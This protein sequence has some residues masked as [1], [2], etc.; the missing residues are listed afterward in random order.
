MQGVALLD[1]SGQSLGKYVRSLCTHTGGT[2]A[3]PCELCNGVRATFHG[4]GQ[5]A[6]GA[7]L[8]AVP[9][10]EPGLYAVVEAVLRAVRERVTQGGGTT[11]AAAVQARDPEAMIAVLCEGVAGAL[12]SLERARVPIELRHPWRLMRDE[13]NALIPGS[14]TA[15]LIAACSLPALSS[16]TLDTLEHLPP[17]G[18][19][20]LVLA[21]AATTMGASATPDARVLG[22]FTNVGLL[23]AGT[24]SSCVPAT[25]FPFTPAGRIRG[26]TVKASLAM[27]LERWRAFF[28]PGGG[29]AA[30]GAGV[31]GG[32]LSLRCACSFRKTE[33]VCGAPTAAPAAP[34]PAPAEGGAM[35]A[36]GGSPP[37]VAADADEGGDAPPRRGA[38][39]PGV[40]LCPLYPARAH[41]LLLPAPGGGTVPVQL[42]GEPPTSRLVA[43]VAAAA[44]T[45][46]K[47]DARRELK[48]ADEAA[49]VARLRAPTAA[50]AAVGVAAAAGAA[51]AAAAVAA[52]APAAPAAAGAPVAA[53]APA[54]AAGG[55][56]PAP[57]ATPLPLRPAPVRRVLLPALSSYAGAQLAT[58]LTARQQLAPHAGAILL[59]ALRAR[60]LST[61]VLPLLP[62]GERDG[63]LLGMREAAAALGCAGCYVQQTPSSS[64][65]VAA[66]GGAG[67]GAGQQQAQLVAISGL[68]PLGSLPSAAS[69]RTALDE[70]AAAAATSSVAVLRRH[71][72]TPRSL[73]ELLSDLS[74]DA[75]RA[76]FVPRPFELLQFSGGSNASSPLLHWSQNPAAL[77]GSAARVTGHSLVLPQTAEQRLLAVAINPFYPVVGPGSSAPTQ[78][79][80]GIRTGI[81]PQ[82][83][84][85]PRLSPSSEV[86]DFTH[87][88][89]P[90]ATAEATAAAA[91]DITRALC[92]LPCHDQDYLGGGRYGPDVKA[93]MTTPGPD[94][95]ARKL[96]TVKVGVRSLGA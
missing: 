38:L 68:A 28:P 7:F 14:A 81:F 34:P 52:G 27:L 13:L 2:A 78:T 63:F 31:G 48:R 9:S 40:A 41:T 42:L 65:S 4:L 76:A 15:L 58:T 61:T 70:R 39:Y 19:C 89:R 96:N 75:A 94:A 37:P 79:G 25:L 43:L 21:S 51:A 18:R 6:V 64:S 95:T 33:C 17:K 88:A 3:S 22:L 36:E 93:R 86:F 90:A 32:G 23:P 44:A 24:H 87:A 30:A 55:G 73:E 59:A 1:S 46:A 11:A 35:E 5:D 83:A 92:L 84:P 69:G 80:P 26:G 82:S 10:C 71:A 56:G 29:A 85:P 50:A 49:R 57:A 47:A 91:R 20:A 45:A 16:L 60:G 77:L 67:A 72:A 54:A 62:T 53:G 8:A 66:G 12:V 74:A